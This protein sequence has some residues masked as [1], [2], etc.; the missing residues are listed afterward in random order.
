MAVT[1]GAL[2]ESAPR[3]TRVTLVPEVGLKSRLALTPWCSASLGYTLIYW[4]KV[5]CP[6]DQM[7]GLVN[8]TQVPF[9]GPFSGPLL[10]SP[11]FVHTDYFAQGLE[12]GLEFRF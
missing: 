2:R 5:L 7:S 6:G 4:N 3:E 10:P 8:I 11:Q 12:A 1:I 9:H